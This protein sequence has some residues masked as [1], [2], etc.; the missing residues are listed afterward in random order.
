MDGAEGDAGGLVFGYRLDLSFD[1]NFCSDFEDD[2][3]FGAVVVALQAKRRPRVD[4]NPF[5]LKPQA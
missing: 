2:P 1:G 5:H 4:D 3:V